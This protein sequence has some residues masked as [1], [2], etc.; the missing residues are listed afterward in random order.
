M[1]VN[2]FF[3]GYF[4]IKDISNGLQQINKLKPKKY[5]LA[6]YNDIVF[7]DT[8]CNISDD[9]LNINN[10]YYDGY[11][12]SFCD[13]LEEYIDGE[14]KCGFIPSDI[15][16]NEFLDISYVIKR[17]YPNKNWSNYLDGSMCLPTVKQ[18][19]LLPY[20]TK[21]IQ[22]LHQLVL[23]QASTIAALESR[24]STLENT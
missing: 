22:E 11:P 1:V 15:S 8:L 16:N 12:I 2:D 14:Y 4:Y 18:E 6:N 10:I 20:H 17:I 7:R 21:A 5:W 24:I 23:T 3:E 19:C 13:S 9:S